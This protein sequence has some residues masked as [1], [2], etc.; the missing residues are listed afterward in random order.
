[1]IKIVYGPKGFGKTKILI[2]DVNDAAHRAMGNV[3]FITVNR[4][5]TVSV[6]FS[7]RMVYTS[8]HEINNSE[9]FIGFI[10]GLLAGNSDIEYIFVDGFKKII[11]DELEGGDVVFECLDNLCKEYTNLKFVLS[12]SSDKKELPDYILK[13]ID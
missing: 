7:V 11:G 4:F 9:R 12:I 5:N 6:D 2:D 8:D 1:M 10:N 3:V 13:Y